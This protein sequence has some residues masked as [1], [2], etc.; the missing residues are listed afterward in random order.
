MKGKKGAKMVKITPEWFFLSLYKILKTA[1]YI[2]SFETAVF[3]V[4][5]SISESPRDPVWID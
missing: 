4:F 3:F 1:K 5:H 2:D